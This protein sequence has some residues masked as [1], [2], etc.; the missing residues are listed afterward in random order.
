M[1]DTVRVL[2]F[3]G[4]TRTDSL[5]KKLV[6]VAAE[7]ALEAGAEVTVVDLRDFAM[8]L[9]DGDLEAASGQPDGAKHLKALM[10]QS[11]AFLIATPE[12]NSM[13][14]AVLKNAIDWVS[15]PQPDESPLI[16]FS[17]KV[18]AIMS[19]SAGA[20][21]GIRGLPVFRQLLSNIGVLVIPQMLALPNGHH[22]FGDN[23]QMNDEKQAEN[24]R[25]LGRRAVAVARA[26]ND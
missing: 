26:L 22:A 23:D 19:T 16:A 24:V 11:Q 5:N 10:V 6:R 13:M 4:S 12:Y 17:G 1:T 25:A 20:L 3:A 14:P 21:G 15:R 7:G 9:Y 18:A 2:A 8:P